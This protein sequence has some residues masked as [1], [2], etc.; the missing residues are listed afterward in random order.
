MTDKNL[1]EEVDAKKIIADLGK[2]DWGSDNEAQMKAVQLLKG[3]AL[4]EDPISNKF[5]KSLSDAS[6]KIA[7]SLKV[8]EEVKRTVR[9]QANFLLG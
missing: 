8:N 6:T 4:S 5:M 1:N 2:T 7:D 9:E 3:L